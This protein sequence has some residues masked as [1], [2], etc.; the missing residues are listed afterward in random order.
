M[1]EF[2]VLRTDNLEEK[3]NVKL[4]MAGYAETQKYEVKPTRI[5]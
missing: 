4:G 5:N 2:E 3:M 1:V